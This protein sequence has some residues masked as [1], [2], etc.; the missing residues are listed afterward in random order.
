MG[1]CSFCVIR[2]A[3]FDGEVNFQKC[4]TNDTFFLL[5]EE[6]T[7]LKRKT[8]NRKM[9]L[10]LIILASLGVMLF[11]QAALAADVVTG[12]ID[13]LNN[14]IMAIIAG[15]GVIF[16]AWGIF[17]FATALQSHDTPQQTAAI[18]KIVGGFICIGIS[19]IVNALK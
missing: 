8:D 19:A 5:E 16:L 18:P 17:N 15:I 2:I 3:Y 9:V 4:V 10:T 11:P 7:K 12:K 1:G 6:E 13:S 14:L